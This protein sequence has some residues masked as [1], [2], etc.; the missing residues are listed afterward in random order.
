MIYQL[1]DNL[2]GITQQLYV[3]NLDGTVLIRILDIR[4]ITCAI[5]LILSII[6]IFYSLIQILR[7]IGGL[8][9][10]K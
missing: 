7:I 1:V 2:I 10:A 9:N 4:Y 5:V 8:F 6:F 3:E